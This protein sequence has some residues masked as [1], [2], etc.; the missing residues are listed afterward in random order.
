MDLETELAWGFSGLS[1]P[2]H[3]RGPPAQGPERQRPWRGPHRC[4][5]VQFMLSSTGNQD[6]TLQGVAVSYVSLSRAKLKFPEDL[7]VVGFMPFLHYIL[8]APS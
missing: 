2:G 3:Q 8:S 1:A 5:R 4:A 6:E 7:S